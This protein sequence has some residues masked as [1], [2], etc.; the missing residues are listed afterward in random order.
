MT[1]ESPS[2]ASSDSRIHFGKRGDTSALRRDY[3]AVARGADLVVIRVVGRGNMLNAPALADFAERQRYAGYTRFVF[4]LE[5]CNGLDST[6]MG[7]M[8]GI[9]T[10]S[11]EKPSA[12]A[13]SYKVPAPT[14]AVEEPVAMTPEEAARE[15]QS[16]FSPSTPERVE[17]TEPS[18]SAEQ[19]KPAQNSG[20]SV[21][22]SVTAV[23]VSND[24][25]GLMAMLGV[26]AF[27]RIRGTADLKQL[28]TTILPEK[29]MTPEER[30][31]LVYKAHE[32]L[33][34]I[35]KRNEAQFGPLLRA[36]SSELSGS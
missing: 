16:L 33:V 3:I 15:L 1:H 12:S 22:S 11:N 18:G 26:D 23:N 20:G 4:D 19:A 2:Q 28:E 6:F 32:T 29:P 24:V 10:G 17:P 5:R 7:V 9:Y 30:S 25:R 27:V 34:D 36:L 14:P 21:L 35:D 13:P 31:R 8:V